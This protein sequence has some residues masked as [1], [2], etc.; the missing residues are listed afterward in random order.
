MSNPLLLPASFTTYDFIG[1]AK[2]ES[3]PKNRVRLLAMANIKDGKTLEQISEVLKIHWKTIQTWL[4]NFRKFGIEGLYVKTSRNKSCKLTKDISEWV[5]SFITMLSSGDTG[6]YIT[7]KQLQRILFEQFALKCSL[8]TV[9]NFLHRLNFSWISSR[10][11]HPK[12]DDEV[13]EIYKKFSTDV[14]AA[15]ST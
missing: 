15:S 10:S 5:V 12:S 13:Q 1:M 7:G 6:G 11:K 3:N 14:K 9:Y 4:R 8:K 2:K